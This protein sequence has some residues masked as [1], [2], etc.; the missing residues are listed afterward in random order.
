[1]LIEVLKGQLINVAFLLIDNFLFKKY[2]YNVALDI[3][4]LL[5]F[6]YKI[7]SHKNYKNNVQFKKIIINSTKF[8]MKYA[9]DLTSAENVEKSASTCSFQHAVSRICIN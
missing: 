4:I 7:S 8:V 3:Y 6:Q 9:K 2:M 5:S 1:M